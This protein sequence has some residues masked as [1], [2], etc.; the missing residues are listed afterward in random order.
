MGTALSA[1]ANVLLLVGLSLLVGI[2]GEKLPLSSH[3]VRPRRDQA[4]GI[5]AEA[6]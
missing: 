6:Q 3:Q 4:S 2:A 1:R 5:Q